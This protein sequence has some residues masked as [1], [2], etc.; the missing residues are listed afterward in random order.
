[1]LAMVMRVMKPRAA[2]PANKHAVRAPAISDSD[3]R[4]RAEFTW[5]KRGFRPAGPL[6]IGHGRRQRLCGAFA[7]TEI[8]RKAAR[9]ERLVT[10]MALARRH[11]AP[12]QP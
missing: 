6:V 9:G 11:G 8:A 4:G 5:Q 7:V 12:Q 3:A 10:P 2:N 1:M